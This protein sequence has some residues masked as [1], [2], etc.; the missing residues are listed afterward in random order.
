MF[1]NKPDDVTYTQMAI[2]IDEHVYTDAPSEE[3][4]NLIFEYLFHLS[5]ML[6]HKGSI[7]T[8]SCYYE[9][10]AF[11]LAKRVFLRLRNPKQFQLKPD[12]TPRMKKVKSCLNYLKKVLYPS[13]VDFEQETYCQAVIETEVYEISEVEVS[14]GNKMY[15]SIDHLNAVEFESCLQDVPKTIRSYLQKI[16]YRSDPVM[17]SSIYISCL[18]TFLSTVTLSTAAKTR[19]ASLKNDT[20]ITIDLINSLYEKER[21]E[22]PILFHLE[23]EMAD[24]IRVLVNTMRH[25]IAKDLSLDLHA[26]VPSQATARDLML[27]DMYSTITKE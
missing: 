7:F 12:G 15:E 10:F 20:A 22:E 9:D 18:L 24:Y 27:S 8:K 21:Y 5:L 26:Y 3:L 13:K 11:Y 17:W 2:Y 1:Y 6:A 14:L 4:D 23:P 25:L 16:P 19:I